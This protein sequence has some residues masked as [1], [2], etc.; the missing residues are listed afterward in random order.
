MLAAMRLAS[1]RVRRCAAE[2]R[3]CPSHFAGGFILAIRSAPEGQGASE[4]HPSAKPTRGDDPNSLQ[5]APQLFTQAPDLSC[6]APK[7]AK[8]SFNHCIRSCQKRLGDRQ[9]KRFCGLKIDD[10]LE[11]AWLFNRDFRRLG[12]SQ[13][14]FY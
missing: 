1:S 3:P 4:A 6:Q 5:L 14:L 2:R 10:Q 13:H 9:A 11:F 7:V 8:I 12:A